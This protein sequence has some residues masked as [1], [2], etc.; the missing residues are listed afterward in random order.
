M[1][2][3]IK[4]AESRI[5]AL[6]EELEKHNYRYYVL[7]DPVISDY[8]YDLMM[9]VAPILVILCIV[10]I[11]MVYKHRITDCRAIMTIGLVITSL[12]L[13][14]KGNVQY[15]LVLVPLVAI[16]GCGT[17]K[18][19]LI[20]LALLGIVTFITGAPDVTSTYVRTGL[21]GASIIASLGE[22][23]T[24]LYSSMQLVLKYASGWIAILFACLSLKQIM[25]RSDV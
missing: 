2:M 15:Y 1:K 6:K 9:L 5:K 13:I 22:I 3:G 16:L 7:N 8:E 23:N 19:P 20:P 24:G 17:F 10:G 25:K 4:E 12:M 18:Y 21:P 14:A 11:A